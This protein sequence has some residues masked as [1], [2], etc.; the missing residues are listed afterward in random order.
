MTF[1]IL[2]TNDVSFNTWVQQLD[3]VKVS[4]ILYYHFLTSVNMVNNSM[5]IES[6]NTTSDKPAEIGKTGESIFA[7]LCEK[8]PSNYKVI[9]TSKIGKKGDF[10]IEYTN[11]N[12]VKKILI[13]IKK[14]NTTVPKKEIDK[15]HEDLNYGN[16]SA[17]LLV[18]LSSKLVGISDLIY[19]EDKVFATGVIPVMYLTNLQDNYSI[20]LHAI[21]LLVIQTKSKLADLQNNSIDK[22]AFATT[23]ITNALVKSSDTRRN[24]SELNTTVNKSI[25]CSTEN[26]ISLELF[27]KMS[28]SQLE[29]IVDNSYAT[30][31][32]FEKNQKATSLDFDNNQKATY[33]KEEEIIKLDESNTDESNTD[34]SDQIKDKPLKK[35]ISTSRRKKVAND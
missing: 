32:D 19:L 11:N 10:I 28:I 23:N 30:S 22:I 33:I 8:L 34:E 6:K 26:L 13:D 1:N 3:D 14:Y 24:L 17:G 31:L 12:V 2:L 25:N 4:N 16:Y 15:F 20:L 5:L 7:K 29:T 27:I 21:Q 9:N 35:I 18:S